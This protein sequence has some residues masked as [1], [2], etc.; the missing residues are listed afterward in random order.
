MQSITEHYRPLQNITEHYIAVTTYRGHRAPGVVA[1]HDAVVEAAP[2]PGGG[3]AGRG[4]GGSG[5]RGGRPGPARARQLRRLISH[6]TDIPF[7]SRNGE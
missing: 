7:K 4:R 1:P 6:N 2:G 3:G 5:L